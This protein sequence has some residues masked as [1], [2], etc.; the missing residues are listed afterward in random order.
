M[1]LT[2][3]ETLELTTLCNALVD[4]ALTSAGRTRLAQM[5]G[6]SAAAR[7]FYVRFMGLSASLGH[8]AGEMQAE[9]PD[10]ARRFWRRPVF[11]WSVGPL[12]A[13]AAAALVIFLRVKPQSPRSNWRRRI[14]WRRSRI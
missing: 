8:Y 2:D 11:W 7:E 6:A 12:A 10:A 13:A 3:Q 4:G 1:N 9:A 5:L 14:M